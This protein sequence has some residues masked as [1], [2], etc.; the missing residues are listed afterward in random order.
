MRTRTIARLLCGFGMALAT[1]AVWAAGDGLLHPRIAQAGGI[2]D[3]GLHPEADPGRTRRLLFDLDSGR[4]QGVHPGLDAVARVLN[5]LA[6]S[7][8]TDDR[9]DVLVLLRGGATALALQP[10]AFARE[11]GHR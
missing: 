6:L 4:G 7:K 9:V 11:T 10:A 5:L 1:G 2:A 3:I 8:V